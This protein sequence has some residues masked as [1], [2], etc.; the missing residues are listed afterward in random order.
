[1][2]EIIILVLMFITAYLGLSW[3]VENINPDALD[4]TLEKFYSEISELPDDED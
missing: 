1:M 4:N 3:L 2:T